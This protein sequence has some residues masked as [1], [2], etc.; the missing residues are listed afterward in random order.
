M[1]NLTILTREVRQHDGLYSLNDLHQ[2]SG[3]SKRHQPANFIRKQHT[4]ELIT[5]I[6]H[7]S[8]SRSD[9][10]SE[11]RL[12]IEV[13]NGGSRRG[14]YVCKELVY[15]YA[16]WVSPKFQLAVIRAFDSMANKYSDNM[17][18]A[19]QH[20]LSKAVREESEAN[21][22]PRTLIWQRLKDQYQVAR[23]AQI[24]DDK[25]EEAL[26]F[27]ASTPA[28]Q[29]QPQAAQFPI[30]GAFITTIYKGHVRS[31]TPVESCKL[32]PIDQYRKAK[33][34]LDDLADIINNPVE[35]KS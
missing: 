32:I 1:G 31:M 15:S 13:I 8:D 18:P 23:Y 35:T 7:S 34:L 6:E 24:P 30:Y 2:A 27:V 29:D 21:S 19:N 28:T 5:E 25:I 4:Q 17:S 14:T 3:G 16:M 9:Q 22:I 11:M 10:G 20:R 26:D 12:A 33:Q